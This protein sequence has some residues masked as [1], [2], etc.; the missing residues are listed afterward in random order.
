MKILLVF[1]SFQ[2]APRSLFWIY[3]GK[4]MAARFLIGIL[5]WDRRID[6]F[7][8]VGKASCKQADKSTG[9]STV[10]I[11]K[12]MLSTTSSMRMRNDSSDNIGLSTHWVSASD[13]FQEKQCCSW[14]ELQNIELQ[15]R[16]ILKR[17]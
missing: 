9:M 1:V 13:S 3:V 2:I 12:Q 8:D 16:S 4:T 10:C 14:R 15:R 17:T 7:L 6:L 11:N 5:V